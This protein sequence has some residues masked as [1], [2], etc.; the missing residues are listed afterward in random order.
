[1]LT[2]LIFILDKLK[3]DEKPTGRDFRRYIGEWW[4]VNCR[5]K[6][7]TD[8]SAK[9]WKGKSPGREIKADGRKLKNTDNVFNLTDIDESDVGDYYCR[10]FNKSKDV[11]KIK[12]ET[13][14]LR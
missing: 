6:N 3:W 1:M 7:N 13:G 2:N 11:G 12:I 14:G 9:L 4:R 10:T 8:V 5:V